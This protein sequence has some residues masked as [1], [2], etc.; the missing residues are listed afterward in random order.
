MPKLMHVGSVLVVRMLRP[1]KKGRKDLV[2]AGF[3][4]QFSVPRVLDLGLASK[5]CWKRDLHIHTGW[6]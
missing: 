4:T 1:K 3:G 2:E 5:P 6:P